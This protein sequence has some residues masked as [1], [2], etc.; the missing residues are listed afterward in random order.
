MSLLKFLSFLEY[1]ALSPLACPKKSI[2]S[3]QLPPKKSIKARLTSYIPDLNV[4][5]GVCKNIPTKIT[6][7]TEE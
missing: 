3:I 5:W 1:F 7:K 2:N 6:L 4:I